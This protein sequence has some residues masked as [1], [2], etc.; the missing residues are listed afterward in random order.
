MLEEGGAVCLVNTREEGGVR[1]RNATENWVSVLRGGHEG[2]GNLG[3]ASRDGADVNSASG[4]TESVNK[5]SRVWALGRIKELVAHTTR[6]VDV[7]GCCWGV[8]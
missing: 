3:C 6:R 7:V 2:V 4:R 5:L 1:S 8:E